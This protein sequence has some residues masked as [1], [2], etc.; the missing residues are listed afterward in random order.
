MAAPADANLLSIPLLLLLEMGL[1]LL[2][3]LLLL[4]LL[5]GVVTVTAAACVLG[6]DG[7]FEALATLSDAEDDDA[8]GAVVV[9]D[10]LFVFIAAVKLSIVIAFIFATFPIP[11]SP[12]ASKVGT[13]TA[14]AV[15]GEVIGADADV[16]GATTCVV[17]MAG[18]GSISSC[19][20]AK[21]L[22]K[23]MR[24]PVALSA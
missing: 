15:G 16:V 19:G 2:A 20:M 21:L 18:A 7:G 13:G 24:M 12:L 14:A 17:D 8:S 10:E 9:V 5:L 6:V 23:Y 4:L 1:P 3:L 22:L 11:V